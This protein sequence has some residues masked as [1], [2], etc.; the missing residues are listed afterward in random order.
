MRGF[1]ITGALG[2]AFGLWISIAEVGSQTIPKSLQ[3]SGPEDVIK[4]RENN[5]TVGLAGGAFDGTYLR[6]ADELGK[7]LDD[8]DQLRVLPIISRGAAGNLED[9]LYLRGIDIAFTQSDVFEYFRTERKTPHLE[10]RIRY[11]IRL[12]VAEFHILVRPE[13]KTLEDLRGEKIIFGPPG[14]SATLT[15]PIVF[16]RLNLP[17]EPVFIDFTTGYKMLLA[18]DAKGLL[19]SVSKPVDFWLKIPQ[20]TGL[21]LLPVP[22]TRA[23]A[24]LYA[25]GEFTSADYPNLIAPG[26]R[27]DTVAVPSVLAVY[28]WPKNSDRY[29][30]VERFVQYLFNRWNKLTQQPF[31]P[32]WRD[33]NLAATVPGWTR[34]SVAE[35]MLQHLAQ[36]DSGDQGMARDFQTY[37]TRQVRTAPRN[38]AERDALFRQFMLWRE[39]QHRQ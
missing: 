38:E 23:F 21:H 11:I 10:D 34:F 4:Q 6:F 17:V 8:G 2:L 1:V 15:G 20:S 31:H 39:Q 3:E 35:D 9:L 16:Q 37:M 19:G 36:G 7:V 30:R 5:W 14:V 26:E 12:P 13:I 32:R 28:N 25:V 24:D 18:G 22:Y 29:R 33:V 27:I